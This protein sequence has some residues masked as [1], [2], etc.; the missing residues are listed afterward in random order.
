MAN[1]PIP[2][3]SKTLRLPVI[4]LV[5]GANISE[6]TI[7]APPSMLN[8]PP[9]FT[10]WKIFHTPSQYSYKNCLKNHQR[11]TT[12]KQRGTITVTKVHIPETIGIV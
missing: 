7:A 3:G 9:F 2:T 12:N 1:I 6:V 11:E 5:T 10:L 4:A 8:S